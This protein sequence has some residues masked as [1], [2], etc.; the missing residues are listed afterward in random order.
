LKSIKKVVSW[1][2]T[3]PDSLFF[4]PWSIS[5][6]KVTLS[7]RGLFLYESHFPVQDQKQNELLGNPIGS[8]GSSIKKM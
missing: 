6:K 5:K 3:A 1:K 2:L 8:T 4:C 7:D